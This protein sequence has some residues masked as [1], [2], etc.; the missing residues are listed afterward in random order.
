MTQPVGA[1]AGT[2]DGAQQPTSPAVAPAAVFTAP[3]QPLPAAE[4]LLSAAVT[5]PEDGADGDGET[6]GD[7][8]AQI[9]ALQQK[10]TDAR[11]HGRTWE[12][13]SKANQ[14]AADKLTA[15]EDAQKTEGQRLADKAAAAELRAAQAE[16]LYH[17]TLAA[18]TY[19]L[20]PELIG[21]ITGTT[22]DE[23]NASAETLASAVNTR[24]AEQVAA[25]IAA[26][27]AAAG[28]GQQP[29]PARPQRPVESMRPGAMPAAAGDPN[30]GNTF[31]RQAIA[32]RR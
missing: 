5:A 26:L 30:D 28:N 29:A 9:A 12:T 25:Q 20:P 27:T 2:A 31:L 13:R 6:G 10:L 8:A 11:K 21:F 24:V 17:R 15:L 1:E 32:S 7:H 14:D 16:G 18:A 23:A 22:E 4:D 3:A 19:S